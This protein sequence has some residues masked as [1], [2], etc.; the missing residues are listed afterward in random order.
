VESTFTL[1]SLDEPGQYRFF[2]AFY[3]CI[4]EYLRRAIRLVDRDDRPGLQEEVRENQKQLVILRAAH[5]DGQ[6]IGR[7]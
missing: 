4:I 1:E 3:L 7:A 2:R 6:P 5:Y